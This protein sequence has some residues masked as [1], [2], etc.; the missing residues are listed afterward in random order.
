MKDVQEIPYDIW[1]LI[2]EYTCTD[3]GLSGCALARTSKT[4]RA[5][6]ASTRFYSLTLSSITEVKNFLVCLERIHRAEHAPSPPTQ[7]SSSTNRDSS[8][9]SANAESSNPAGAH[10][11][12]HLLIAFLPDTC[13]APQRA[14]RRWTDY[15]RDERGLVFQLANDHKAWAAHKAHWNRECVL[16]VSRLL[17]LAAPTLRSLAVLQCAEIRLPLV[18]YQPHRFPFLR[19]LT[20]LADDRLFVRAPGGGALVPNQN[21]PSDFDLH[22]VPEGLPPLGAAPFPALTHLHVVCAGPK[23][24]P[25][26]KTLP[27]WSAIA[28]AVTHLRISQAGARTPAV[29]AEMLGVPPLPTPPED[30]IG[31]SEVAEGEEPLAAVQAQEPEPEPS[32]PSLETVIVQMSSARKTNRAEDPSLRELQHIADVCE[33]EGGHAPRVAILRGRTYVPGY[34][35]SR[36]KWEW[37]S[38]MVGGG[39]CWTEDEDHENV[40]KDFS[41]VEQPKRSKKSRNKVSISIRETRE[42]SSEASAAE[43]G[44]PGKKWWKVLA[45]GVPRLNRRRSMTVK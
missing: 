30:G 44:K 39:G 29:L 31:E 17:Q 22:G 33:A 11:I 13:D 16:H 5:L 1:R 26:E 36:L 41:G 12:H 28:P 2:F 43:A 42:E 24:H 38:R 3:G 21:D 23:L 9:T 37:Q 45:N 20:L 15:A 14:F 18:H 19:E 40:W 27:M 32:Y 10:P 6:S 25:W 4:L 7:G 35:E 34:W 8:G